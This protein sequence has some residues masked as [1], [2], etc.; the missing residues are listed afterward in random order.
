VRGNAN[1]LEG[2]VETL[3]VVCAVAVVTAEKHTPVH[4]LLAPVVVEVLI[5]ARVIILF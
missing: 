4:A 1:C 2:R 5:H 3:L